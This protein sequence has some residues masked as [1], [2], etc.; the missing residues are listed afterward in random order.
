MK[1]FNVNITDIASGKVKTNITIPLFIVV[2]AGKHTPESLLKL[3]VRDTVEGD[4]SSGN[5]KQ[6]YGV[7]ADI[8]REAAK[9]EELKKYS[10]VIATIDDD[11]ERIIISIK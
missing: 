7:V 1:F 10:G 9:D 6:V 3:I 2:L 5:L 11:G 4:K 8:L